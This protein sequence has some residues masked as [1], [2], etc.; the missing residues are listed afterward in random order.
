[1]PFRIRGFGPRLKQLLRQFPIVCILGPRQCGKTT[2]AKSVLPLWRYLD[3]EKP[4]DLVQVLEDPEAALHRWQNYVI[5]DEAQRLPSLFPVLRSFVDEDRRKKGR[6]LLLGSASPHLIKNTSESLAGRVSFLDMT[7]F[8]AKEVP[9]GNKLWFR[10]GFPEA[11]LQNNN[12][13]RTDW[14]EAYTRTFIERDL[15]QLGIEVSPVQMR[16]LWSMLAHVHGGL[17]DASELAGSLG[18]SY[19][20]VNRYVEILEQTFLVRKLRP[21]FVNLGKRLVKSP[22]VYFRDSGLLH[23][24]LGIETREDLDLHPKKGASWEG[25]V[26]EQILGELSLRGLPMESYF[27]RTGT[28]QETDFLLKRGER[29]IPIEIKLHSAP[30]RSDISGLISCMKDLGLKEGYVIRPQGES[31]SLGNGIQVVTLHDLPTMIRSVFKS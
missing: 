4:S 29:I 11:Y 1:M 25:F 5:F 9:D 15:N 10:G 27:W 3:F 14:F 12:S 18:V 26:I 20:T 13:R 16:K 7:P 23:Y 6:I 2:F 17:W 28:G 22:K 24:F 30:Q 31:Y 19:H 21:Y 8:L